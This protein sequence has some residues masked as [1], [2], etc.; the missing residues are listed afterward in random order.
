MLICDISILAGCFW[1]LNFQVRKVYISSGKGNDIICGNEGNDEINGGGA[2]DKLLGDDGDDILAGGNGDDVLD[3]GPG[4]NRCSQ[5][6][7]EPANCD[8]LM[9]EIQCGTEAAK[10]A[11]D[12]EYKC[13]GELATCVGTPG[14]DYITGTENADVIV[15]LSGNDYI[16]AKQ[17]TDLVCGNDTIS[18][19]EDELRG[20]G[21][22]DKLD[23]G[24]GNDT[25][26]G[27]RGVDV[28]DGGDTCSK[29]AIPT[30]NCEDGNTPKPVTIYCP[31]N[32]AGNF[33][34]N[35]QIATCVGTNADDIIS[36]GSKER[37]ERDVI[38]ALD[39]NDE[40]KGRQGHDVICGNQGDDKING[41]NGYDKIFGGRGNDVYFPH[42]KI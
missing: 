7:I 1:L 9:N 11:G 39:G 37:D 6:G 38:V 21:N 40:I 25:V 17:G 31:T 35:G 26:L 19:D 27:G 22:T 32:H 4:S 29:E 10:E 12:L 16:S 14:D 24:S 41:G 28:I 42:L 2:T 34:C 18:G 15:A 13:A 23:G 8:V 3:G 36:I 30:E 33:T 5:E 20:G